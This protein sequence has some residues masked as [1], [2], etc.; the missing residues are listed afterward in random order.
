[1][2]NLGFLFG[3]DEGFGGY[4]TVRKECGI[5]GLNRRERK[6]EGGVGVKSME[7]ERRD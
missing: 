3:E 7:R 5:L 6:E 1:M 2:E 4:G